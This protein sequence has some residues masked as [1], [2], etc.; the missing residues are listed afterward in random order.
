MMVFETSAKTGHNVEDV[1][2]IA[3]KEILMQIKKEED[4][5][6]MERDNLEKKRKE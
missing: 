4:I 2:S 6:Q 5:M 1:F 3:G